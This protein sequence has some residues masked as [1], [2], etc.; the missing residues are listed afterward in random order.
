[1]WVRMFNE[2]GM[3]RFEEFLRRYA[4]GSAKVGDVNRLLGESNLT[5]SYE[6]RVDVEIPVLCTKRELAE[7]VAIA[8][9]ESGLA[10]LPSRASIENRGMWTWLA[11]ATFHLIKPPLTRNK[12]NR[13]RDFSY[14]VLDANGLRFYRHRVAG[15]ARIYWIL[16]DEPTMARLFLGGDIHGVTEFEERLA[17]TMRYISNR[18]LVRVVDTL[19]FDPKRFRQKVGAVSDASRPGVLRRFMTVIDQLDLTYDLRSMTAE[20]ILDLLP[21]EFDRW[22]PAAASSAR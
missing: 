9:Q 12:Q 7:K 4:E 11:A 19:Y 10:E 14:Y 20:Q 22:K 15:P 1:M 17:V 8:F 6:P 13:L 5:S 21:R 2:R 18:E 3:Q 16:R